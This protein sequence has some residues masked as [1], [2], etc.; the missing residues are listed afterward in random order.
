MLIVALPETPQQPDLPNVETERD[1]LTSLFPGP[2]HTLRE[3]AAATVESVSQ[4]LGTHAWAH[5]S[6]HGQQQLD[7]PSDG[8]LLLHD[9]MLAIKQLTTQQQHGE[10]AFLSACKTAVGGINLP[11]EVITLAAAL[12]FAGWRHVIGTLWSVP[13]NTAADITTD[14][15]EALAQ[16]SELR[17]ANAAQALHA[18]VVRQRDASPERPSAW[19]PFIHAGA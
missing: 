17:P 1:L 5:F 10:F 15:Y 4:Q 14:V 9:G 7:S 16:H 19:A 11:D 6:C 12:R 2:R 13:D 8:G 3:G 18:A